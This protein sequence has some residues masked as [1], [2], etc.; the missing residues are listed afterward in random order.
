MDNCGFT[1]TPI[2]LPYFYNV[3]SKPP[4]LGDAFTATPIFIAKRFLPA[5]IQ[6]GMFKYATV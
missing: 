3:V 6:F 5:S 4:K 1:P 2:I